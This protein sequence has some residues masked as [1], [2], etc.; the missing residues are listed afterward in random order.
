MGKGEIARYGQFLLFQQCFQKTCTA[1]MYKPGLVWET[2]NV[3]DENINTLQEQNCRFVQMKSINRQR[4][5]M[6]DASICHI[7]FNV[8]INFLPWGHLQLGKLICKCLHK[9]KHKVSKKK[10]AINVDCE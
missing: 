9:K 3:L 10:K 2:V 5:N 6:L 8:F 1:D 4:K 7:S